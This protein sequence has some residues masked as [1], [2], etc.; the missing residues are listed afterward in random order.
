M[1][2]AAHTI[3]Q[4]KWGKLALSSSRNGELTFFTADVFVSRAF[5]VIQS[6]K[7]EIKLQ[8]IKETVL[9]RKGFILNCSVIMNLQ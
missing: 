3:K 9:R 4:E 6:Q 1:L 5:M 2:K 7:R 8:I